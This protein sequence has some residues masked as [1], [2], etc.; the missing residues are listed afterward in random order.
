VQCNQQVHPVQGKL[1]PGTGNALLPV[2]SSISVQLGLQGAPSIDQ[3]QHHLFPSSLDY[4]P[5][6]A[7]LPIEHLLTSPFVDLSLL[8]H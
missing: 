4:Q 6:A 1:S 8:R 3:D 5:Q 2:S 7:T